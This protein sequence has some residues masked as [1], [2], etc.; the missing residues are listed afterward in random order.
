MAVSGSKRRH[1]SPSKH[2]LKLKEDMP[3]KKIGSGGNGVV[4]RTVVINEEG[5]EMLSVVKESLFKEPEPYDVCPTQGCNGKNTAFH[6]DHI[7]AALRDN[8]LAGHLTGALPLGRTVDGESVM[9]LHISPPFLTKENQAYYRNEADQSE[10]LVTKAFLLQKA[11][12]PSSIKDVAKKIKKLFPANREKQEA[13]T[14]KLIH[15]SVSIMNAFTQA[16]INHNSFHPENLILGNGG[17]VLPID[18]G[19]ATES[20]HQSPL[21][22]TFRYLQGYGYK[23]PTA[24]TSCLYDGI[25]EPFELV[26]SYTG[27]VQNTP[28]AQAIV[29]AT[30]LLFT[31]ERNK[32]PIQFSR[33]LGRI[34]SDC[35]SVLEKNKGSEEQR[36]KIGTFLENYYKLLACRF[37]NADLRAELKDSL[38]MLLNDEKMV[39]VI[40][41]GYDSFSMRTVLNQ[42]YYLDR[43]DFF[44]MP[45]ESADRILKQLD[46]LDNHPTLWQGEAS[47]A[48]MRQLW[49][50]CTDPKDREDLA[51]SQ[52]EEIAQEWITSNRIKEQLD[53]HQTQQ[54]KGHEAYSSGGEYSG[55][56][57]KQA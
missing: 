5:K 13:L 21:G 45:K 55:K 1:G 43:D 49:E 14:V 7:S 50:V 33:H 37:S 27:K 24:I 32:E 48:D 20:A 41:D 36:E 29:N 51:N 42:I 35:K 57:I 2:T 34:F 46:D 6:E 16:N 54:E 18:V 15:D 10:S 53:H 4:Y 22:D 9:A 8:K 28:I 30:H 40:A 3:R 47:D 38:I 17:K 52:T 31:K 11:E 25:I 23:N 56:R 44:H 26:N 19:G 12:A 39:D